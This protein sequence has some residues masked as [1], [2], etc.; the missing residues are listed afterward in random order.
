[1]LTMRG[2]QIDSYLSPFTKLKS[3]WIKEL[4]INPVT[5]NLIKEKVGSSLE[6]IG[7][8]DHFLNITPVTQTLRSTV[9][10]WDLLKL[11]SFYKS[12]DSQQD[13]TA[14]YKMGEKNLHQLHFGQRSDL[15][16][17]QRT[18]ETSIVHF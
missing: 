8:G 5:P 11:R 7:T 15:Q 13:K 3:R 10:K 18:Q 6:C 12:K 4:N 17:I 16:N 9:N 2:M 1:M 14:T